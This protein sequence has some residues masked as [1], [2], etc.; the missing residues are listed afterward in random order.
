[1]GG[2]PIWGGRCPPGLITGGLPPGMLGRTTVGLLP[3]PGLTTGGLLGLEGLGGVG[4]TEGFSGA[5]VG[6]GSG[7]WTGGV[8]PDGREPGLPC[9]H[10]LPSEGLLAGLPSGA[11]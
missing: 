3:P 10:L 4:R 8:E 5:G 11:F 6:F 7:L 2:L 1:M 9:G